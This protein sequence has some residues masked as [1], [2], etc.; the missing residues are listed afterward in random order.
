MSNET[1]AVYLRERLIMAMNASRKNGAQLAEEIGVTPGAISHW[2]KGRNSNISAEIGLKLAKA[3]NVS[4]DW[5]L[6]GEGEGPHFNYISTK[7]TFGRGYFSIDCFDVS[8][9]DG[10]VIYTPNSTAFPGAFKPNQLLNMGYEP[11]NLKC[12]VVTGESMS[13]LIR[14]GEFVAVDTTTRESI[15]DNHIYAVY[16]NGS[17]KAKRLITTVNQF[18]MKSDNDSYPDEVLG[19]EEAKSIVYVLGEI[20]FRFGSFRYTSS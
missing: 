19:I 16:Y 6:K 13:P 4:P 7:E 14:D 10:K 18:I 12:F 2:R 20:A 9:K 5:L 8:I 11:N 17:I 1:S 3:L 15:V